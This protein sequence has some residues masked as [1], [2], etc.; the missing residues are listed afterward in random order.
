MRSAVSS[1]RC[2]VKGMRQTGLRPWRDGWAEQLQGRDCV[3]CELIGVAENSWGVRVFTG[4][5]VDA[6]LPR[7]GSVLGYTVA[8]WNGSHVSEPTQLSTEDAAGYWQ[9]TIEVGRA[10]EQAF[11]HAKMNYQMLGNS[12]PHLHTHIVPRPLLDPAPHAPLPWAYL[13]EGRQ[14]NEKFVA[15]AGRLKSALS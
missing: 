3:L 2:I 15:A 8:V 4:R 12:V 13:D 9:E 14:D 11:E 6:Y 1:V 5:Y 10:V 7:S